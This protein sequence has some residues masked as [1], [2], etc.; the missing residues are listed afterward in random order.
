VEEEEEEEEEED[1]DMQDSPEKQKAK[2]G[3][4]AVDG[5]V[6]AVAIDK[7]TRGNSSTGL[8]KLRTGRAS[9]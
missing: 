9:L 1:S 3:G 5:P 2:E 4:D 7:C 6:K 8:M